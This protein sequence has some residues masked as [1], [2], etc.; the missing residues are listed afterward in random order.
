M[1]QPIHLLGLRFQNEDFIF[2]VIPLKFKGV[3]LFPVRMMIDF[4]STQ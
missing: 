4:V 3:G 1:E 2:N